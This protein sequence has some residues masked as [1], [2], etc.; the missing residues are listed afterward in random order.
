[1]FYFANIFKVGVFYLAALR[2]HILHLILLF[3]LRLAEDS[4]SILKVKTRGLN[5]KTNYEHEKF[6]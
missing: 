6:F 4:F 1:M 3:F 2:I 5:G